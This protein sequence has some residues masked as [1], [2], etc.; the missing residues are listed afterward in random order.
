MP[1]KL[2][3][4]RNGIKYEHEAKTYDHVPRFVNEMKN[5]GWKYLGC[6]Y[7]KEKF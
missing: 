6:K 1:T 2:I 4:L 7:E 5:G 3:F